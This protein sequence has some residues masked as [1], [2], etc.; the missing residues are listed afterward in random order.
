MNFG[1]NQEWNDPHP[2]CDASATT[3]VRPNFSPAEQSGPIRN[4]RSAPNSATLSATTGVRPNLSPAEAVAPSNMW[5]LGAV[6]SRQVYARY[7]GA[8]MPRTN[9]AKPPPWRSPHRGRRVGF[10]HLAGSTVLEVLFLLAPFISIP[11]GRPLICRFYPHLPD[12]ERWAPYFRMTAVYQPLR[13]GEKDSWDDGLEE[14]AASEILERQVVWMQPLRSKLA[15]KGVWIVHAVLL[16]ASSCMFLSALSMQSSTL[17][18]VKDYSAWCKCSSLHRQERADSPQRR[19][20]RPWITR[21]SSI[22]F[23]PRTIASS[24]PARRST[25]H[26]VRS[27]TTVSALGQT[28]PRTRANCEQWATR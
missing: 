1:A 15:S 4:G 25:R 21:W 24:A 12:R 17:Q 22:M 8:S 23:P 7:S 9:H 10:N 26:G 3:G 16:L 18:H 14:A 27:H 5:P 6:L 28:P 2:L 13:L 19:R 20:P 11:S